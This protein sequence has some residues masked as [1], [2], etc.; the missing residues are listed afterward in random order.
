MGHRPIDSGE[1]EETQL[2]VYMEVRVARGTVQGAGSAPRSSQFTLSQ[3]VQ[4]LAQNAPYLA[5]GLRMDPTIAYNT[6]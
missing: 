4:F 5:A 6:L 1:R 2:P 3:E